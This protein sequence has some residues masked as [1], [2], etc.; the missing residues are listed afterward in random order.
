MA[1]NKQQHDK[2]D[3]QSG[4]P[5]QLDKDRQQPGQRTPQQQDGGNKPGGQKQGA[6]RPQHDGGRRGAA[7][8]DLP[9][10]RRRNPAASRTAKRSSSAKGSHTDLGAGAH[11]LRLAISLSR[12]TRR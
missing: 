9:S 7:P 5:V 6:D 11:A 12:A 3:A 10:R 4:K 2:K 8:S 1:D